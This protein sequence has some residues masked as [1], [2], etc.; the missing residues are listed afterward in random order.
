MPITSRMIAEKRSGNFHISQ[1]P[2]G[3]VTRD[4][5][6]ESYAGEYVTVE[7]ALSVASVLSAFTILME[8]TASLPLITYRRLTRGK[9][10]NVNSPYYILLH[11]MPNPEHTSM[12]YREFIMGHLLGWGNHFSQKIWDRRGVPA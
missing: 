5:G 10:R 4:Y 12:V 3:W 8:D 7:G 1:S 6:Q 9:E 11:D 2:P